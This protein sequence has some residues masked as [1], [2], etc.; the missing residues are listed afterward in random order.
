MMRL[1]EGQFVP[2]RGS[3]LGNQIKNSFLFDQHNNHTLPPFIHL[4]PALQYTMIAPAAALT[5]TSPSP[6][7][8]SYSVSNKRHPKSK[9]IARLRA[10]ARVVLIGYALLI[11]VAKAQT[12]STTSWYIDLLLKIS[13]TNPL[14]QIVATYADWWVLGLFTLLTLY[15]CLR[16]N[17]TGK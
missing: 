9:A 16:R 3:E 5:I 12:G 17:Y 11:D 4:F 10:T 1:T 7:T 6:T 15:V 13:L 8:I 2:K 14:V